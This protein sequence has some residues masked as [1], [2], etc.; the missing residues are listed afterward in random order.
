MLYRLL[1]TL[2][3]YW[4]WVMEILR[5]PAVSNAAIKDTFWWAI[6]ISFTLGAILSIILVDPWV[7]SLNSPGLNNFQ[8]WTD[9][10]KN[11]SV[12]LG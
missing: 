2:A 8:V 5:P 4:Y 6:T 12:V 3:S 1:Y 11:C 9:R 7:S 10:L